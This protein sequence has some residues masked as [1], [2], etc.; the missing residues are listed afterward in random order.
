[1]VPADI[2]PVELSQHFVAF[3]KIVDMRLKNVVAEKGGK[4]EKE[5][6]IQFASARQAQACVSVSICFIFMFWCCPQCQV[7]YSSTVIFMC[8]SCR[9]SHFFRVAIITD[10]RRCRVSR[11]VEPSHG[12]TVLTSS[13][14]P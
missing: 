10:R 11:V 7:W 12:F 6:L 14:H 3:G 2:G 5:A 13:S 8:R 9:V 1:M 4:G